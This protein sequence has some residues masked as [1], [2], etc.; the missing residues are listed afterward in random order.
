MPYLIAWTNSVRESQRKA[1]FTKDY[2]EGVQ[3]FR[4]KRAPSFSGR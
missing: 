1:G 3:A 4:D 2:A